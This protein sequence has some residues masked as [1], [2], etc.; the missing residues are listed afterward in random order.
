MGIL[1]TVTVR[2]QTLSWGMEEA[3]WGA[4]KQFKVDVHCV[5][6]SEYYYYC[7]VLL[8]TDVR[9]LRN[10]RE[11]IYG[12]YFCS[13]FARHRVGPSGIRAGTVNGTGVEVIASTRVN[14]LL[15][16]TGILL[17]NL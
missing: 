14:V 11:V 3:G 5:V 6:I 10:W 8:N 12:L 15:E 4:I 2:N 7:S 16:Y 1:D 17:L 13:Y 9:N